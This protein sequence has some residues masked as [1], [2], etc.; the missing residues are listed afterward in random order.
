MLELGEVLTPLHQGGASVL[1]AIKANP[2]AA[3]AAYRIYHLYLGAFLLPKENEWLLGTLR[4]MAESGGDA[5]PTWLTMD[6]ETGQAVAGVCRRWADMAAAKEEVNETMAR[7]YVK[8]A[9]QE[10]ERGEGEFSKERVS[11][12]GI[13]D[14]MMAT[15]RQSYYC[16]SP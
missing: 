7:C 10:E 1:E 15:L 13:A 5:R 14:G 8:C 11:S 9:Q 4:S 6:G 2:S 16:T 3:E 12:R